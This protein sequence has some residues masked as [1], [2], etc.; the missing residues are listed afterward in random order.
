MYRLF[1]CKPSRSNRITGACFL[2][3]FIYRGLG[4]VGFRHGTGNGTVSH[5]PPPWPRAQGQIVRPYHTAGGYRYLCGCKAPA[6][7]L[8]GILALFI[9]TLLFHPHWLFAVLGVP[10]VFILYW[11]T[12]EE[13]MQLIERFGNDYRDYMQRVP[14]MNLIL[15]IVRLWK[16]QN[17]RQAYTG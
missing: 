17:H 6:Q 13:E 5:V 1:P 12:R 7:Y 8:G 14:R 3:A 9:A 2:P 16:R 11:S 15:G 4:G 10:G